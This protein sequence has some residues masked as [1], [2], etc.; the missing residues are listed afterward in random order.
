ME[1]FHD[2]CIYGLSTRPIRVE[3]HTEHILYVKRIDGA[4]PDF[5]DVVGSLL[6]QDMAGS[7][8]LIGRYERGGMALAFSTAA[9][10]DECWQRMTNLPR[11]LTIQCGPYLLV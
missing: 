8:E 9:L 6:G 11:D 2:K 3:I 5:M 10:R 4:Y 7:I 1:R